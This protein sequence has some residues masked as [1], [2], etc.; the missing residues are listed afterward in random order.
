MNINDLEYIDDLESL[1]FQIFVDLFD[2]GHS[3]NDA[4]WCYICRIYKNL[5][6]FITEHNIELKG[7]SQ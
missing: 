4:S 6:S 3:G 2:S 5:E 7:V 1:I